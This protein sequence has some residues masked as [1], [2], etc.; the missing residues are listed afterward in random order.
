MPTSYFLK[1]LYVSG[2]FWSSLCLLHG[3]VVYTAL[4]PVKCSIIWIYHHLSILLLMDVWA[5]SYLYL[6]WESYYEYS[7]MSL[8][9]D[10][11]SF[12]LSKYSGVK[13]LGLRVGIKFYFIKSCHKVFKVLVQ[14]YMSISNVCEIQLFHVFV[15]IKYCLAY[16]LQPL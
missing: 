1:E 4:T 13:L 2:F 15:H 3:I 8:F 6:L 16:S 7:H 14:L 9:V 10:M 12:L 5:V 11:F